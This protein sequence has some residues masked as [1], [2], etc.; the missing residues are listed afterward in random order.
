[1]LTS[2]CH[3]A[4]SPPAKRAKACATFNDENQDPAGIFPKTPSKTAKTWT[5]SSAKK[6]LTPRTPRF[7]DASGLD[8]ETPGK[9]IRGSRGKLFRLNTNP[10]TP[11]T[12]GSIQTVYHLARH[13]FVRNT[14]PV[15][16]IGRDSQRNQIT[17]FLE[18]CQKPH[19]GG[20]LYVSGPPGT[21]KSAM[22]CEVTRD[23][24]SKCKTVNQAYINCMSVKSMKELY[25]AILDLFRGNEMAEEADALAAL[26]SIFSPKKATV[27]FVVV[28]DEVDNLLTLHS[29]SLYT[30]FE[31]ALQKNSSLCLIGI[32]NAL[33]LTDRFLPRLK[34]RNLKPEL[35]PFLPYTAPQIKDIITSRLQSLLPSN[36]AKPEFVP[37]IHP[38]AIELC[39]RKVAGQSGDLRRAFEICRR[40]IEYIEAQTKEMYETEA[41]KSLLTTSPSRKVLGEKKIH[42]SPQKSSSSSNVL[43]NIAK[44][45]EKLTPETAPRVSIAHL[46]KVTAAAF[47][48]GVN[49]RLKTLNLQQKAVLCSLV[50]V[51]KKNRHV[52]LFMSTGR[53]KGLG[54]APTI[55]ELYDAYSKLC[56]EEHVLHPLSASEFREV[57]GSLEALSLLGPVDMKSGSLVVPATP[58][59]RKGRRSATRS[60]GDEKRVASS[61]TYQEMQKGLNGPGWDIL[62][63][64]LSGENAL[65]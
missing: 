42:C 63:R 18:R 10:E 13:Q 27:S 33:D 59:K 17:R 43:F 46:N 28:L 22:V 34:S 53:D 51:E 30:L 12:P 58:S 45:L 31:L 55:K 48:H 49:G 61:V 5:L 25:C 50:A 52:P 9:E 40:A 1:M 47:G 36:T 19:A 4:T 8:P 20:C 35:L 15:C 14:D 29:E 6:P 23:V 21:G 60:H 2:L 62:N 41:R 64:I 24:L 32:A 56:S 11:M 37:F 3:S 26:K 16:L 65:D 44:S 7:R 39:S 54:M 38:A 57:I